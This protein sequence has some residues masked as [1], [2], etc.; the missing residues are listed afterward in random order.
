MTDLF[1]PVTLGPLLPTTPAPALQPDLMSLDTDTDPSNAPMALVE[2]NL[3]ILAM[4]TSSSLTSSSS[5]SSL[6][7]SLLPLLLRQMQ[8]LRRSRSTWTSSSSS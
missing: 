8:T 2:G 5:S 7:L 3:S 4:V 6:L 1:A